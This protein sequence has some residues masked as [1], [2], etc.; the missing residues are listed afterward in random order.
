MEEDQIGNPFYSGME[1][2]SSYLNDKGD[3]EPEYMNAIRKGRKEK[4]QKHLEKSNK[5]KERLKN[6]LHSICQTSDGLYFLRWLCSHLSFK[7]TIL[8][9]V[10]Q[11]IDVQAMIYNEA[12][13]N[14]WREIR[15]LMK[16]ESINHIEEERE[17]E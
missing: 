10:G 12:R 15:S 5:E 17:N 4:E 14:V 11:Q 1:K 9:M 6:A 13:R 16:I 8:V 7:D 2:H 3:V